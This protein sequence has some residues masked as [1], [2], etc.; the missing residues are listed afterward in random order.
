MLFDR[1][2]R[3]GEHFRCVAVRMSRCITMLY[4]VPGMQS[5]T[6]CTAMRAHFFSARAPGRSPC[7]LGLCHGCS[8]P[9]PFAYTYN[10][11]YAL[12]R[13]LRDVGFPP[14]RRMPATWC[15]LTKPETFFSWKGPRRKVKKNHARHTPLGETKPENSPPYLAAQQAHL[16]QKP[17]TG[18]E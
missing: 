2:S 8:M 9:W 4:P 6:T 12:K 15:L 18:I 5:T 16:K 1:Q 3:C 13:L 17:D 14:E 11:T 7:P 10:A